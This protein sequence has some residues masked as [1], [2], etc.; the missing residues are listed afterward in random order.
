MAIAVNLNAGG[1]F[2][3]PRGYPVRLVRGGETIMSGVIPRGVASVT[4]TLATEVGTASAHL[5]LYAMPSVSGGPDLAPVAQVDLILTTK[6][7]QSLTV[8]VPSG[9]APAA[10]V[11][12]LWVDAISGSI[13]DTIGRDGSTPVASEP[14]VPTGV[15]VSSISVT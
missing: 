2:S 8:T 5:A 4:A 10:Y 1:T 6:A 11:V 14:R 9:L 15:L 13:A 7:G 3:A 12:R